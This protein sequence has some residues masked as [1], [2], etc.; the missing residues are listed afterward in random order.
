MK[1]YANSVMNS[2]NKYHCIVDLEKKLL[3]FKNID[4]QYPSLHDMYTFLIWDEKGG[5][6][7]NCMMEIESFCKNYLIGVD[8][9]R[10][11]ASKTIKMDSS[12]VTEINHTRTN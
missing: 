4:P 7:V 5:G 1:D 11:M 2:P 12:G 3:V 6:Y 9:M 10:K 8:L